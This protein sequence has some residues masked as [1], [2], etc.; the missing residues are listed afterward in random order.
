MNNSIRIKLI[1]FIVGAICLIIGDYLY[2]TTYYTNI[3]ASNPDRFLISGLLG[4]ITSALYVY[5]IFGY[6]EGFVKKNS[7]FKKITLIALGI[8][9]IGCAVTHSIACAHMYIFNANLLTPNDPNIESI[10]TQVDNAFNVFIIPTLLGVFIGFISLLIG[11]LK[12]ETVF[13]K[14]ALFFFP[15][16]IVVI[17]SLLDSSIENFPIIFKSAAWSGVLFNLA[18]LFFDKQLSLEN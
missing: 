18:L 11:I 5:G 13:S 10:F 6:S 12:N 7:I 3:P 2:G 4:F 15:L 14:K 17:I 9:S 1:A 8:F 16:L